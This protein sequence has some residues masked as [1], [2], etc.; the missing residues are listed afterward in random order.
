V[1]GRLIEQQQGGLDVQRTRQTVH[2]QQQDG[3]TDTNGNRGDTVSNGSVT[4]HKPCC[5]AHTAFL[6]SCVIASHCN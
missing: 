3:D 5:K 1:V 4:L 6:E 2:P